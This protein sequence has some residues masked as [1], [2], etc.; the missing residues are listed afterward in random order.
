MSPGRRQSW[1]W[2]PKANWNSSCTKRISITYLNSMYREFKSMIT[3]TNS[4][5]WWLTIIVQIWI[6]TW[7]WTTLYSGI[8]L[9]SVSGIEKLSLLL[10]ISVVISD[11]FNTPKHTHTHTF[12]HAVTFSNTITSIGKLAYTMVSKPFHNSAASESFLKDKIGIL[13]A[14]QKTPNRVHI[15]FLGYNRCVNS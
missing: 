4:T 12:V 2:L 15:N 11:F 3:E 10:C 13:K 7:F 9:T 5:R 6:G 14:Q 1:Y 8:A